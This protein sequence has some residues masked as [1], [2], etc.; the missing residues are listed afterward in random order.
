MTVC[1]DQRHRF[2]VSRREL[3]QV[4]FSGLAGI[5]LN[6]LVSGTRLARASDSA[7]K[8]RAK[9]VVLVFLSGGA[10]HQDTFDLKP[11][12]PAEA[13][14]EFQPINTSVPGIQICEHL[15]RLAERM[16]R[17]ALVR[18]MSHRE[19]NHLPATHEVL[20]GYLA[21]NAA[22]SDLDRV[23]SRKDWPCYGAVLEFLRPRRD[24]VP[25]GVALPTH[26][27]EGPLTWPGQNGGCLG[28][29][30]DPWQI[31]QDPNAP[32]F[33]EESLSLPD[34]FTIDRVS[35]RR[36]LLDE[37]NGR[38]RALE[39][40]SDR[41]QFSEKQKVALDMLASGKVARAFDIQQEAPEMR[42]RYGRHMFGQSLLLA[43]RLLQAGVP[44]VQANMGIVQTWDT[45]VANFPRLKNDLLPPLDQGVA[46]L[47]DDL[48]AH[49][50]LDETLV[51][52]TGE[53]GRTP[54]ISTLPGSTIPG[55]DHWAPV[56]TAAFA[57]AGV[58]GGQVIGRTD[59]LAAYS[60][61]RTFSLEDLGATV[62]SALGIDPASEIRDQLGRP[63]QLNRGEPI[64]PLYTGAE[65]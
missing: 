29:Q 39:E 62:Y 45:H 21:P 9:A 58:Q 50:M 26:L 65:V 1:R 14:G 63:L 53:F 33:R 51:I 13:R 46:A 3:L 38:R 47:L 12:G 42:D 25:S 19:F 18:S 37:V 41:G 55:R 20:T 32:N 61:T 35:A 30:Y 64:T 10:A 43:R 17:L 5:G 23:A 36:G 8:A 28:P 15:P 16:D 22:G 60:L 59:D 34:G 31:R 49:G 24:G 2:G 57:G 54:R 4:G 7:P 52:I 6:Q 27:V 40:L 11:Q 48:A 56:F 44:I